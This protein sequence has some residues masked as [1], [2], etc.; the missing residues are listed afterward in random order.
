MLALFWY[1]HS[2]EVSDRL[3]DRSSGQDILIHHGADLDLAA[4]HLLGDDIAATIGSVRQDEL[5]RRWPGDADLLIREL[6]V[7]G[8]PPWPRETQR[9]RAILNAL[10]RSLGEGAR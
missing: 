8:G 10:T 4:A 2:P 6:T 9:R 1:F 7:S 5:L 3:Y